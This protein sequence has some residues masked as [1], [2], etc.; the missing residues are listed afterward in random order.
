MPSPKFSKKP[1]WIV[2]PLIPALRERM[3]RLVEREDSSV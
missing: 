3:G 2:T 1:F